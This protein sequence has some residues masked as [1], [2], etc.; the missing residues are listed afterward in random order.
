MAASAGTS[1]G[2]LLFVDDEP[3]VR[4]TFARLLE[5]EGFEVHTAGSLEEAYAVLGDFTPAFAVVDLNLSD[6]HGMELV[7]GLQETCP[8]IRIV[9]LTGYDSIASSVVAM[10]SGAWGYLAKPVAIERLVAALL[11][12]QA[13]LVEVDSR[14]MSADR[15]RWEHIQRVFEQCGRNVSETARRLNMH[16]RTL[17][18]ILSK[19]APR[20]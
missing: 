16:R 15:I 6:G 9:V 4:R 2:K 14:P 7:H 13:E 19:R 3:G 5:R 12:D 10:K 18:R 1:P 17:Q 8:G 11:G 20:P